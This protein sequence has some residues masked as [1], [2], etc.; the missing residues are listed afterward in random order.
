VPRDVLDQAFDGATDLGASLDECCAAVAQT[1]TAGSTG[2]LTQVSVDVLG[3]A[4][5]V[6]RLQLSVR[7]TRDGAPTDTVLTS[8]SLDAAGSPLAV[9]VTLPDP[10]L[11]VAGSTYALVATYPGIPPGPGQGQGTWA[12][13]T[14]DGYPAGTLWLLTPSDGWTAASGVGADLFFRTYVTALS[15]QD[16][17]HEGWRQLGGAVS[18]QGRCLQL[19]RRGASG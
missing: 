18:N 9:R 2:R 4:G 12:G 17:R 7:T 10:P 15:G 13:R 8:V 1:F 3:A 11:V 16:C 6:G 19:V 14:G 5:A